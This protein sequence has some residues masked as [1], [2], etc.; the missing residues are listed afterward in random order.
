MTLWLICATEYEAK[1]IIN[2]YKLRQITWLKNI[3]V[4][5]NKNIVLV[6]SWIGKIMATIWISYLTQ[7]FDCK[8]IINI[9]VVWACKIKWKIGDILLVDQTIQ[10]DVEIPFRNKYTNVIYNPLKLKYLEIEKYEEHIIC[11]TGDKVMNTSKKERLWNKLDIDI[12]DMEL[13]AIGKYMDEIGILDR[14]IAI[15][16]VSDDLI[17]DYKLKNSENTMK[18]L[19]IK[20]D[21]VYKTIK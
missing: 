18:K 20:L 5:N 14:L 16:W 8:Y 19:C 17:W 10:Y 11:A 3:K 4:Y 9:W 2:Y 7:N 12:V 6:I 1:S 21:K 13:F 15:K